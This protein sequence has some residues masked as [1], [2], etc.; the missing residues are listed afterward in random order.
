MVAEEIK[1]TSGWTVD[2]ENNCNGKDTRWNVN[3]EATSVLSN[4]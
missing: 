1:M 3:F 4:E 2:I